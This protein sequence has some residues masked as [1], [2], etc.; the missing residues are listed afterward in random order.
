MISSQ[1]YI[2]EYAD[3][4]I[5]LRKNI[6]KQLKDLREQQ[7]LTTCQLAK[8]IDNQISATELRDFENG[9]YNIIS[10][11]MLVILAHYYGKSVRIVFEDEKR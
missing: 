9:R 8:A 11:E 1:K 10:F 7:G 2:T 6:G 5:R 4:F 3:R